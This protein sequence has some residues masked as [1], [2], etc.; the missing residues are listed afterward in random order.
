M[1]GYQMNE[2]E[3]ELS[4]SKATVESNGDFFDDKMKLKNKDNDFHKSTVAPG[5]KSLIRH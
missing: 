5:L 1:Q 2:D 3:I 4:M